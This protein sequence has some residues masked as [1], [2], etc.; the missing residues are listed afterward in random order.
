MSFVLGLLNFVGFISNLI[1]GV[2]V[3]LAYKAGV[4]EQLLDDK[5]VQIDTLRKELQAD[6]AAPKTD[7]DVDNRLGGGT[8]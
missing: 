5:Q 2:E 7:K 8:A 4:H 6:N 1:T 3:W